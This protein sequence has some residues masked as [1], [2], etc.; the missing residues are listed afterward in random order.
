M[1][2]PCEWTEFKTYLY[3]SG[4]AVRSGEKLAGRE[5]T[6]LLLDGGMVS[7]PPE[8]ENELKAKYAEMISRG[9]RV[10]CVEM[11]PKH[12]FYMMVELDLKLADREI[13]PEELMRIA[14]LLQ[15]SVI[16]HA[17]AG[18]PDLDLTVAVTTAP[19]KTTT[20]SSGSPAI[21]SGIHFNWKIPVNLET[22]WT[23]RA[24][25]MR[26]LEREM[27]TIPWVSTWQDMFDVCIFADNG[28]RMIGSRKAIPCTS[29]KGSSHKMNIQCG[30][31]NNSGHLD[32]GR[33]YYLNF[34]MDKNGEID[35]A[36]T[37]KMKEAG[38]IYNLIDFC[39]IRPPPS[40]L[41]IPIDFGVEA[42]DTTYD[43][44]K[45]KLHEW[46]EIDRN[47]KKVHAPAPQQST[48]PKDGNKK[49]TELKTVLPETIEYNAISTYILSE[50]QGS[51]IATNIKK[52]EKGDVYIINTKCHW[53][54]NKKDNHNH[55][56][57]YFIL[58][59]SGCVQKCF[60]KHTYKNGPCEKY[61]SVVHKVPIHILELLFTSTKLQTARR[62]HKREELARHALAST[63]PITLPP[64]RPGA[65]EAIRENG[66]R[67]YPK[68]GCDR[69]KERAT[70]TT[71]LSSL[72]AAM[73]NSQHKII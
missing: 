43:I 24:W 73:K 29:C 60:S 30:V 40:V 20:S 6:H 9:I 65:L 64:P 23:L 8:R 3:R 32:Q 45:G 66:I 39:S 31:C 12:A 71:P 41:P 25:M 48:K 42:G 26:D 68:M 5:R 4:L 37:D 2:T 7:C 44:F 34:M 69:L 49:N 33:P 51:P 72:I 62:A 53:C 13:F 28:L 46:L 18:Y 55:A 59:A 47:I 1:N 15:R 35:T 14:S 57:I 36:R 21:Q 63:A 61:S 70:T 22:A 54:C 19:S 11:K 52:S 10:Y 16:A 67:P 58:K 27:S 17:F 50:F 56:F 38:E